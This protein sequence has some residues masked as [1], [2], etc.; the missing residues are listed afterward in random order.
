MASHL[1]D[2]L[3]LKH[4]KEYDIYGA[5]DFSGGYKYNVNPASNFTRMDLRNAKKIKRYFDINFRDGIDILVCMAASAQEIRSYFTPIYNSSVNDDTAI[6]P[7]TNA[8][9]H[10]VRHIVYFSS[11]SRYGDGA[12][13]DG[14]GGLIAQQQPPFIES[15]LPAPADPYACSKVYVENFIK[16]MQ[17]VHNFTYTIWVPHNAFSPRQYV[18]PYRNFLAIW[19][20]LILMGKD[21]Y[22]YGNGDQRRAISWVDDYNPIICESLFNSNTYNQ[23]INI[24]GDQHLSINEWYQ[25]VC[26]A[27]EWK[28]PAV[29]I[30][31]RPGEVLW[32][33]CNHDK[34]KALTGFEN[35][36]ESLDAMKQMWEYFKKI[37]PRKFKYLKDFE[38]N[39]AKIPIT[40]R[41][42]MF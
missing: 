8:I 26:E 18:D 13:I 21:C 28:R 39:S 37:G 36:V 29:H 1:V 41:K 34:A 23:T 27:S 32:A 17:R 42:K 15:Y 10:G 38:I 6:V 19:M 11:M 25:I 5:D 22:I 16:A 12:V 14:N 31:G 40:W 33:F 2:Y 3:T 35:K 30:E 7:I 20:N 4:G 24:G 9:N